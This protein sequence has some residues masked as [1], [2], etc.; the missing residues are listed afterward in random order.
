MDGKALTPTSLAISLFSISQPP[1]GMEAVGSK[2][3][4]QDP[5]GKRHKQRMILLRTG[6]VYRWTTTE[7]TV[8]R[9]GAG[10][11][12]SISTSSQKNL[13]KTFTLVVWR[14]I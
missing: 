6:P 3:W 1:V 2:G 13:L 5:C 4:G 12:V 10:L 11:T 14:A 7:D 9:T 8:P